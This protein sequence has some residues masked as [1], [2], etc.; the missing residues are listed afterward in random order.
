MFMM[1]LRTRNNFL[2]LW[3]FTQF[4][5]LDE[6]IGESSCKLFSSTFCD[7]SSQFCLRR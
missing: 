3:R 7:C 6:E 5:L 1:R 2:Y 4:R